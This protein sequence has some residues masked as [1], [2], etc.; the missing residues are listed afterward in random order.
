M[1]TNIEMVEMGARG[2]EARA[3]EIPGGLIETG[4]DRITGERFGEQGSV[5]T[6]LERIIAENRALTPAEA[7]SL[8]NIDLGSLRYEDA[9]TSQK[10]LIGDIADWATRIRRVYGITGRKTRINIADFKRDAE[11]LNLIVIDNGRPRPRLLTYKGGLRRG[12]Y[13]LKGLARSNTATRAKL[14]SLFPE[15]DL[16][17][18]LSHEKLAQLRIT[19]RTRTSG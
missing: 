18:N 5:E 11:G 1:E 19:G 14:Q 10:E 3:T 17:A 7:A 8:E 12:Y 2:A 9:T 16:D 4:I 13:T 15:V 6:G